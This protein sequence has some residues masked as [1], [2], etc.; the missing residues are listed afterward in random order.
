M[1]PPWNKAKRCIKASAR[2]RRPTTGKQSLANTLT[3]LT[4]CEALL[5]ELAQI[6]PFIP[7]YKRV[8]QVRQR[9]R[10]AIVPIVC[11]RGWQS[12][13]HRPRLTL[14]VPCVE[15]VFLECSHTH[16]FTYSSLLFALVSLSTVVVTHDRLKCEN[17]KCK[18]SEIN[19][20]CVLNCVPF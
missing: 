19:N 8:R 14:R 4:R 1:G 20:S 17:N 5:R 6:H 2:R 3:G 18:I 12:T 15:I 13:A 16:S 10:A 7:R 9:H 11:A